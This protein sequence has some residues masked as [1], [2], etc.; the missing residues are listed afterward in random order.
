M[1]RRKARILERSYRSPVDGA[2]E[3][4]VVYLPRR[5]ARDGCP[6]LVWLHGF[7]SEAGAGLNDFFMDLADDFGYVVAMPR[8]KGSV[9]Y[10]GPGELD[11]MEV[12]RRVRREFG[13]LPDRT[14]LGGASMGGTG[15]L[16]LATRYPHEFAAAVPICGWADPRYWYRKW[17]APAGERARVHSAHAPMLARANTVRALENLF[18]IPVYL[19]HG[20][21]D[22]IVDVGES[23]SAFR[24][25]TRLG[26]EVFYK[27]YARG[28]HSGFRRN[29]RAVFE[30]LEGGGARSWLG[31]RSG[32]RRLRTR[33]KRVPPTPAEIRFVSHSPRHVRAHWAELE[34]AD[35]G[36]RSRMRV[37][38]GGKRAPSSVKVETEN[39][40]RLT[41]HREGSPWAEIAPPRGEL[42]VLWRGEEFRARAGE[43]VVLDL[44][45]RLGAKRPG[46]SGPIP[47]AFREAFVVVAGKGRAEREAGAWVDAWNGHLVP[48]G[49]KGIRA[50][51]PSDVTRADMMSRHL[52]LFGTPEENPLVRRAV[53]RMD[54]E[55]SRRRARLY[56][57]RWKADALGL[58]MIHP[59]PLAPGRYVVI[60]YGDMGESRKQMETL[61][62]YWP[63]WVV[64]D[65]RAECRRTVHPDWGRFDDAVARGEVDPGSLGAPDMP[66]RYLPDG[67]IDA[68]FF[69]AS[70][71]LG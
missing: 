39:V 60:C 28:R 25:L 71:R 2:R 32:K 18:H 38:W 17:Y 20:A 31:T 19:M 51:S 6:L 57:R 1:P 70:W 23:R 15:A 10:D 64:F 24:G 35:C 7:G 43:D 30:W 4:Y 62:W 13:T 16:R 12:V 26:Y 29:W 9:F 47:D 14:F 42:A 65:E 11:A 68:G 33:P 37:V 50:R 55:L 22:G 53:S 36:A 56:R 40:S 3:P 44:G 61:G 69:D 8:G 45:A 59:N 67:W 41:L 34:A 49:A 48:E 27:E 5:R 54:V 52:V 66:L 46:L 63:D 58:R 21:R